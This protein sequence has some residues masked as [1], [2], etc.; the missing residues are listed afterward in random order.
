MAKLSV[1]ESVTLDGVM[2]G[3]SSA[4]EDATFEYAGWTTPYFDEDVMRY[5]SENTSREGALL[6]GRVTYQM[7]AAAWTRQTGPVAD[8][9]NN[10]AK[11]VVST[12]LKTA[13]WK[14]S[15]LING[16]VPEA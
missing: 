1:S 11:Y 7:F 10:C 16:S 13:N 8:F 4:P 6:L 12:T 15:T 3:P 9:M 2:E 5:V 14:N